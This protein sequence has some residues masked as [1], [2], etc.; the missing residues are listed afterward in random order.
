MTTTTPELSEQDAQQRD[1]FVGRLFTAGLQTGELLTVYLGDR[2]GLYRA[3][4][5]GGPA[6][7][8]E[9]AA[10]TGTHERYAR[11]WLEQQ[12]VAGI[13]TVDDAAAA[14]AARCYTLPPAHAEVLTE[15]DS[16]NYLAP[17]A[18]IIASV[19]AQLPALL[20]AF[21]TGGGVPYAD[22]GADAREGQADMNRPAYLHLLT[23]EWLPAIPAVHARLQADPPARVADIGCG[24]GWSGIAI[25]RAYPKVLVDGYD[26][27]A[28]SIDLARANAAD[29]G[30][31][32][33]VSFQTQDAAQAPAGRYDLVTFFECV[34]DM[35]RPVEALRAARAMLAAGGTVLVMDERVAEAFTAPGDE[36]ERFFYAASVL[37]CLPT[38]MAEQPSS[39]TGTVMRPETLR[40]YATE[41]GFRTVAI[42]P[43]EHPFFRFYRLD[44]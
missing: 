9:L 8:A 26:T 35:A 12:A 10:R 5:R 14:P 32:A 6:T 27:D 41:A 1:E 2:L 30:V 39:G 21:R 23:T 28:P 7:P 43:I 3:L 13:L 15:R 25:A 42:L 11:E 31:A 37:F 33:R 44:P 40:R 22:F 20:E 4:A 19:P 29:A 34:H 17:L 16:L 36:M 18:R 38:G 24:A